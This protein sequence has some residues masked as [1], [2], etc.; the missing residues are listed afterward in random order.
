MKLCKCSYPDQSLL[1]AD[2]CR[3]CGL[4]IPAIFKHY[5]TINL[6][7]NIEF[8]RSLPDNS[9]DA[10]I[11]DSPYGLGKEPDPAKLI[12]AWVTTG[13]MEITGKGFMGKKWDAFVPQPALWK[14]CYRVLKPGGHLLSFFGTRTY[15]WGTLAIRLAGFEIRDCIQWIYGS[16]FPKSKSTLKPANEPICVARKPGPMQMLN[17]DECRIPMLDGDTKG[18]FGSRINTVAP[19]SKNTYGSFKDNTRDADNSLGRWPSNVIFDEETVVLLDEQSGVSGGDKRKKKIAHQP[20][21]MNGIYG[22]FNGVEATPCYNDKGGASRFFYVAKA[23]QAE[24]K[25]M[26]HP[27]IKPVKLMV[28][29]VKLY[30][31]EGGIVLDPHFGSGPTGEACVITNRFF[32]AVDN[33]PVSVEEAEIRMRRVKF[34]VN[35]F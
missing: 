27:T 18:E 2:R 11:T 26:T 22:Y 34:Q 13:Y 12:Q 10:V 8:I 28:Q 30:C 1:K 23:S 24:R 33:D 20:P 17:I 9:I 5:N 4:T 29:L 14:E 3:R 15:D 16:G 31:P 21:G 19:K 32:I 6:S 25:G 7:D 35:L